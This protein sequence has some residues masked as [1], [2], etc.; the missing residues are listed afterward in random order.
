MEFCLNQLTACNFW[1][2]N[3]ADMIRM[4]YVCNEFPF[5]VGRSFANVVISLILVLN[6]ISFLKSFISSVENFLI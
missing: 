1:K 2:I 6:S 3:F 5:P 4:V